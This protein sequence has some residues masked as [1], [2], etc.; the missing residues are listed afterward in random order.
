MIYP[1]SKLNDP[2]NNNT[3]LKKK[4]FQIYSNGNSNFN[5]PNKEYNNKYK[6]NIESQVIHNNK[7]SRAHLNPLMITKKNIC[8]AYID[9]AHA[10]L[11]E[12]ITQ[13]SFSQ[14]IS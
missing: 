12:T 6:I 9:D 13:V 10:T 8:T 14:L 5:K 3:L 11:Q 2:S 7:Q 4:K 1:K